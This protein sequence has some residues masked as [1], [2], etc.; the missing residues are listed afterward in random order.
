MSQSISFNSIITPKK[1]L[2]GVNLAVAVA[3]AGS[4]T[5]SEVP[6]TSLRRLMCEIVVSSKLLGAFSILARPTKDAPYV[7]LYN[8][9]GQF[10]APA[11]PLIGAS[12][13]LTTQAVGT[14][15]FIMD[16]QGMESVKITAASG[17][18]AGSTVDIYVGGN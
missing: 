17:D 12:G 7:T 16:V 15:W 11:G 3:Q 9:T 1:Q 6:T 8:A 2:T 10:I 18:A 14:G 5:L 13:D 4:T